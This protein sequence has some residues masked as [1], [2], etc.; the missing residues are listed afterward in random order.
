M[1]EKAF[2]SHCRYTEKYDKKAHGLTISI[3]YTTITMSTP[4]FSISTPTVDTEKFIH[5]EL[6]RVD[7][8]SKI[9]SGYT[10]SG[11]SFSELE[12]KWITA[13]D[14]SD[15]ATLRWCARETLL[16][17]MVSND[18]EI[19]NWSFQNLSIH[20][21]TV[22]SSND[23]VTLVRILEYFRK[24]Y[25][26]N[27]SLKNKEFY[28]INLVDVLLKCRKSNNVSQLSELFNEIE[29]H[30]IKQF[31]QNGYIRDDNLSD[32]YCY[33]SNCQGVYNYGE[34]PSVNDRQQTICFKYASYFAK[35]L[36]YLNEGLCNND[37]NT[38]TF[39]YAMVLAIRGYVVLMLTSSTSAANKIHA[40][41]QFVHD[42]CNSA[43]R[44]YINVTFQKYNDSRLFPLASS[45]IS[46]AGICWY[47]HLE[48]FCDTT[49][50]RKAFLFLLS[51]SVKL[52]RVAVKNSNI[53][54][55]AVVKPLLTMAEMKRHF[56]QPARTIETRQRNQKKSNDADEEE[57][58]IIDS[59]KEKDFIS[60]E[61]RPFDFFTPT[62]R[63]YILKEEFEEEIEE[64]DE[65]E[66]EKEEFEYKASMMLGG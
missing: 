31:Y 60:F 15:E 32:N 65:E 48:K 17:F 20:S 8:E 6:L 36:W 38:S 51:A 1:P 23:G 19:F 52:T 39:H 55:N 37:D 11:L 27:W 13:I 43:S 66:F 54:E 4:F 49:L 46:E 9:S 5:D 24:L 21:M 62:L 34:S 61:R 3:S 28:L 29:S 40:I 42:W 2:F 45:L 57:M 53:K 25:L 47:A 64:E 33:C 41:D 26:Y 59:S 30:F 22:F 50:L 14:Y 56:Q 44:F 10:A 58:I 63:R 18:N 16:S 7:A 35:A 12:S